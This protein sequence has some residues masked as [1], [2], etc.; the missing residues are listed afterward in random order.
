MSD[1]P[2]AVGDLRWDDD[3][4]VS[5]ATYAVDLWREL[6]STLPSL[7]VS[8]RWKDVDV[9]RVLDLSIPREPSSPERV[10]RSLRQLVF[11][12]S[13][14]PGHP[15]FMAFIT[16]PGT[17]PG[18][19][20][21]FVA[22]MINQNVG[23]YRLAPA[24]TE[25]ERHVMKWFG[26]RFGLPESTTGGILCSGG[27]MANFIALKA[28][29]DAKLG[30]HVRDDGVER[31]GRVGI[32]ASDEV[33][34]V[35]MRGADMLGLGAQCVRKIPTD[36]RLR[37]QMHSLVDAIHRDRSNG[38]TPI[39][40][41]GTAGT[42]ATGSIDPLD[43]IADVCEQNDLWFHVDGAY[44]ALAVLSDALKPKLAGIERA[45]SIAFDPH[46]WLYVPHSAGGVVFRDANK[47]RD[48]FAV[49][50]SYVRED[51]ERTGH[52][53]DLHLFG[54]QFS[55]GFQALKVWLSLVAHGS[56]AYGRRI[57]HDAAL[58]SYMAERAK[59]FDDLEVA[60][61]PEL[62]ICCFRYA[63]KDAGEGVHRDAYLDRLNERLMTELQLDGRVFCSNAIVRERFWLRACIV[64]FRTEAKDV[65][66][67]L[68]VAREIGARLHREGS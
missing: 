30:R 16:G 47:L 27:A 14:Y 68:D 40:V 21:D 7:P 5:L 1:A 18:I 50:A 62:S 17:I 55:R 37:M 20:G 63:P 28:M 44:G 54:P 4:A 60:A 53:E 61:T 52:G 38:V 51:K 41:V 45:D 3:R 59:T 33:H 39:C 15:R 23:G 22:A 34:D 66:A 31:A 13:M 2:K 32:Y 36:P 43:A 11:D 26:A 42:V 65:D 48:A 49:H 6:L 58:A 9:T 8:R 46:K 10:R 67:V 56:D 57:G 24:A 29:R 35:V 19:V 25:I 12:V 64:N